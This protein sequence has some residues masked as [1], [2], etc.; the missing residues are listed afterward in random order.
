MFYLKF[1][2]CQDNGNLC[3]KY[4]HRWIFYSFWTVLA[5]SSVA[6]TLVPNEAALVQVSLSNLVHM[7]P[8]KVW[9]R[10]TPA[11]FTSS[12]LTP[13]IAILTVLTCC[14]DSLMITRGTRTRRSLGNWAHAT[15][16]WIISC[17]HCLDRHQTPVPCYRPLMMAE[18]WHGRHRT[19]CICV[20]NSVCHSCCCF[21]LYC[22]VREEPPFDAEISWTA[23]CAVSFHGRHQIRLL[24][25]SSLNRTPLH[26]RRPRRSSIVFFSECHYHGES[27]VCTY[28]CLN[29]TLP[30]AWIIRMEFTLREWGDQSLRVFR[31]VLTLLWTCMQ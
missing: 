10:W 29:V 26:Q 21:F 8:K 22:F 1:R 18:L 9:R 16:A 24:N 13:S 17:R 3:I 2:K 12:C 5:P 30:G 14:F 23:L 15:L 11:V 20:K 28:R 27:K 6:C 7:P 4:R 31:V 25:R 19:G